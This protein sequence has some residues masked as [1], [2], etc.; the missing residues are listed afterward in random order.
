MATGAERTSGAAETAAS[1]QEVRNWFGDLISFPRAVVEVRSVEDIVA[2]MR[3]A[4]RY[5]APVRARGSGHSTTLCGQADGGTVVDMTTMNRILDVGSDTVTVEAGALLIDVAKELERRNL[6]FY[7]N[8]ELGNATMGSLATCATKDASMPGEFGQVNSYCVGMK[9]VLPSGEILEVN[10]EEP[11]LLRA[12]RSSYGMFGIVYEVT[13]KVRPLQ[14]MAVE[15]AVF[16]LNA[17]GRKLPELIAREQSIMMY[18]FPYLD[19]VAVEFRSYAGP[20]DQ[21]TTAPSHRLWRLRNFAWKTFMPGFGALLERYVP[22]RGVRYR[23]INVLNR[24]TQLVMFPR[25]KARHTVPTDQMIRYPKISGGSRYTFS[26]WAFPE[27]RY[28]ETLREYFQFAKDY[29]RRTGFRPNM[30]H[31]GYRIEQDDSSLFSYTYDSRVLTIDPVSTGAPGW[32]DFLD[33]YN[34]F[35]S[36]HGGKPLFNQS[37]GLRPHQVRKAFGDRVD[38]F[39]EYRRR[40]DPDDRLLNSYFRELFQGK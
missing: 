15:H 27:E 36:E 12:A 8:I 30:L 24:A 38:E 5:P 34:E 39:E 6:Q 35:C 32:K 14:A 18:I 40:Y 28:A 16:K 23:L 11:G 25:L 37:W 17:F 4:D 33:A 7:V 10:E 9:M 2:I 29:Y 26:I 13:F 31:V 3:D 22:A 20:A 19:R 1:S 21:A